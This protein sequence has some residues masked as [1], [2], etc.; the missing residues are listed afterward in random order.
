MATLAQSIQINNFDDLLQQEQQHQLDNTINIDKQLN[1]NTTQRDNNNNNTEEW[2][3]TI[4]PIFPYGFHNNTTIDLANNNW[5]VN[6]YKPNKQNNIG[7]YDSIDIV[8]DLLINEDVVELLRYNSNKQHLYNTYIEFPSNNQQLYIGTK[9]QYFHCHI[10]YLNKYTAINIQVKGS[11]SN[12]YNI[13]LTNSITQGRV[14]DNN[15]D[16]PLVLTNNWNMFYIDLVYILQTCFNVKYKYATRVKIYASCRLRR[17][18][19][20]DKPQTSNKDLPGCLQLKLISNNNDNIQ[21]IEQ[22]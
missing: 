22:T 2:S 8:H 6:L 16:L 10:K 14:Y 9:L 4:Y 7:L 11:D 18:F 17:M 5:S 21:Q 1:D 3:D 13:V 20:A 15:I 19:F 12:L